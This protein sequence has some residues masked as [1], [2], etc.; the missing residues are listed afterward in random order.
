MFL[1]FLPPKLSKKKAA[2]EQREAKAT[3]TATGLADVVKEQKEKMI[4]LAASR[5]ELQKALKAA[6]RE[7]DRLDKDASAKKVWRF[8]SLVP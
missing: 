3:Q 1:I 6:A 4:A 7:L 8:S 5:G 2:A